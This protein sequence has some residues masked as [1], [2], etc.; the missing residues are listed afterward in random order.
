MTTGAGLRGVGYTLGNRLLAGPTQLM[1]LLL[2]LPAAFASAPDPALELAVEQ[3]S[4]PVRAL[5]AHQYVRAAP[6]Q[7]ADKLGLVLKHSVVALAQP[8]PVPGRGCREGWYALDPDGFVCGT[9]TTEASD[10][11]VPQRL[12]QRLTFDHPEPGEYFD[13][14]ETGRY[15]R[16]ALEPEDALVPFIYG[17]SW[18]RWRAPVWES[19]WAWERGRPAEETLGDGRKFAFVEAIETKRGTV[20]KRANGSIIPADEVFLYPITAF[21]GRDFADDAPPEGFVAGWVT[22][23]EGVELRDAANVEATV[24]GHLDFQAA[25][26]VAADAPEGWL[27]IRGDVGAGAA[28]YVPADQVAVARPVPPPPDLALDQLWIDIDVEQ[29]VL[30]VRRGQATLFATLVSTG[31]D[32]KHRGTPTGLY[33]TYDKAA[34][35]DM[36][37]RDGAADVYH[38]EKVPWIM[39][40]WP[41]YALHGTFWHWGFGH[42]ASHGCVNLSPRDADWIFQRIGPTLPAGWHTAYVRDNNPG[43]V[44]RVRKGTTPVVRDRRVL[45]GKETAQR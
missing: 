43:T 28:R 24:V 15:D 22:P 16:Q 33:T 10:N 18:R 19:L 27:R 21:H 4:P 35:G 8:E 39:H 11:A 38:V 13:Y 36:T 7:S 45:P 37:S 30:Q 9:W 25:V 41:R 2:A 29:Q 34:W 23:Y 17:K 5:K 31:R 26:D 14:L 44:L 20:L 42:Q 40:F 1:L 32:D 6:S 12:P 3:A